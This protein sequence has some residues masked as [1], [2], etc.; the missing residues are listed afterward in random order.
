M[1]NLQQW[2]QLQSRPAMQLQGGAHY[3]GQ[4][5]DSQLQPERQRDVMELEELQQQQPRQLASEMREAK[6]KSGKMSPPPLSD[7]G[8]ER[9]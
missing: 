3:G 9:C 6:Q 2:R 5:R 1:Q 8:A 4:R 7:F